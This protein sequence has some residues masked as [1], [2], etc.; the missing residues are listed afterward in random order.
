MRLR[1]WG[2]RGSIPTPG[3]NTVRY[4]GNTPCVEVRFGDDE[5]LIF[6]AGTGICSLGDAL[7]NSGA[8]VR[9]CLALSHG[10]WDHIQGFPFFKPIYIPGNELTIV[11]ARPRGMTLR[12]MFTDLMSRVY[13][14]VKLTD[15]RAKIVFRP[16]R[17]DTISIFGARLSTCYVYHPAM[18]L[19]YRLE[20][21]GKSLVY[22]TDNE[23]FDRELA[24]SMKTVD[25]VVVN[26]YLRQEG[27]PNQRIFDFARGANVLIH[28][29]T[30]TP[31]EYVNHVGWGHSHYM[32]TLE[33]AAR[34]GVKK[35]VLFHHEQAHSDDRIDEILSK[36]KK[37]IRN[38]GYCFE[39]V[40][41]AEGMEIAC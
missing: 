14:P 27:N 24:G 5:L 22:I 4:G 1:F 36:C 9:A 19:G 3:K 28:D 17:E 23:P 21:D 38:R 35:L 20:A 2:T 6:D 18:T 32:F 8:P 16:V 10:H 15:L 37:E 39:C 41:A 13:F 12:R 40:A 25:R 11:G 29:A 7:V 31:E 26:K 30:Y 33:V 34:A